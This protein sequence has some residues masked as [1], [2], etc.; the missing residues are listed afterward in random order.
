MAAAKPVYIANSNAVETANPHFRGPGIQW[1]Y[2][3]HRN[4]TS[5]IQDGGRNT[6]STYMSASRQ[7]SNAVSTANPHFR[8]TGTKRHYRGQCLV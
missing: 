7:N 2:S 6:G 4:R 8:G 1:C 3:E 5:E